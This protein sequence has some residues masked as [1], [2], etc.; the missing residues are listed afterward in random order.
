MIISWG[1]KVSLKLVLQ[2]YMYLHTTFVKLT[3]QQGRISRQLFHVLTLSS[4]S[5]LVKYNNVLQIRVNGDK[6]WVSLFVLWI[7]LLI[8]REFYINNN[9]RGWKRVRAK[10]C[11]LPCYILDFDIILVFITF[12]NNTRLS[13]HNSLS[14]YIS[15]E[16]FIFVDY[17]LRIIRQ[18]FLKKIFKLETGRIS[19]NLNATGSC[20]TVLYRFNSAFSG[21]ILPSGC[22]TS[23]LNFSNT[24]VSI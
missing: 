2:N 7:I 3:L 4:L 6:L 17:P 14:I 5:V 18:S 1:L 21:L 12:L 15:V 20:E 10:N 23:L 11:H 9:H 8:T 13:K 16:Y 24:H 19:A 22:F